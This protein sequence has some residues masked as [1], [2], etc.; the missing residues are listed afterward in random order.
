MT[1]EMHVSLQVKY[2]LFLLDFS[3]TYNAFTNVMKT[4]QEKISWKYV[5]LFLIY[6]ILIERERERERETVRRNATAPNQIT[7]T[8]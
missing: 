5:Q 4:S 8:H 6:F 7:W 1:T 2:S 3:Q